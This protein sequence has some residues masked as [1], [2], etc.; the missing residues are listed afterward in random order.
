VDL[1]SL[2]ASI[3]LAKKAERHGY[4]ALSTLLLIIYEIMARTGRPL[5][6]SN[7]SP[8]LAEPQI[9]SRA[10]VATTS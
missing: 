6:I 3:F 8:N 5:P 7:A 1:P 2:K 10:F 4:R 9:S